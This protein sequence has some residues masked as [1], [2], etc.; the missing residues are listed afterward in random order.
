MFSARR[1]NLDLV[2]DPKF[3]EPSY[4]DV[5]GEFAMDLS[6]HTSLSMNAL[7]ASDRVRVVVESDPDELEQVVS[8]TRNAQFWARLETQWSDVLSSSTV[9]SA[10]C[11][12]TCER[13]R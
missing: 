9:L 8:T 13:A 1:G 2:I 5:F 6:P 3:G 11:T 12:R 10:R 4:Y 7:Y